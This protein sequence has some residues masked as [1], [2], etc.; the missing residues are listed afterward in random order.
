MIDSFLDLTKDAVQMKITYGDA[1][2]K[3]KNITDTIINSREEIEKM[4][5]WVKESSRV[6]TCYNL[7]GSITFLDEKRNAF[8]IDF[9]L[10]NECPAFYYYLEGKPII[11][12]MSYRAG[13]YLTELMQR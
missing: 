2:L 11:L 8:S 1:R 7:S 13:V 5:E 6:S 9:G 10:S 12:N 3:S 4:K